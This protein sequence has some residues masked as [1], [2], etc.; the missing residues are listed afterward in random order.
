MGTDARG[1][2]LQVA[3]DDVL[4]LSLGGLGLAGYAGVESD[5][6]VYV[7]PEVVLESGQTAY[8]FT[9]SGRDGRAGDDYLLFAG[10]G[11]PLWRDGDVA[12]L[13]K[14][15]GHVLDVF[16]TAAPQPVTGALSASSPPAW[17]RA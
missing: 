8:V 3:N 4:P 6:N 17:S 12:Y 15:N 5:Q 11:G 2:F 1:E 14:P 7:F 16:F 13:R 10:Q 9:G